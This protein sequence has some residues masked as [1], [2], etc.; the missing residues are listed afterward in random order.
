MTGQ[1]ISWHDFCA[2]GH[3]ERL[4]LGLSL[5]FSPRNAPVDEERVNPY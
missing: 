1:G 2:I 5:S 4:I 3:H